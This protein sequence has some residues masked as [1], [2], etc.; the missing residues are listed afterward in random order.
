MAARLVIPRTMSRL[1]ISTRLCIRLTHY[2]SLG[3]LAMGKRIYY[4]GDRQQ[5][6]QYV[7]EAIDLMAKTDREDADHLTHSLKRKSQLK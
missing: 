7:S 6:I 2:E 1:A 3:L 5:G 4:E